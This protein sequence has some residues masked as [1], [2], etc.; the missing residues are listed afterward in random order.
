MRIAS[1]RVWI[2]DQFIP[3]VIEMENGIIQNVLPYDENIID[4]N[5]GNLRIVPGFID[6]H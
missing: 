5:Y 4:Q 3:A 2:A 1:K 6:M